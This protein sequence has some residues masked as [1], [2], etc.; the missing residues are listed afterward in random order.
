MS[1]Y[2]NLPA[3]AT[4]KYKGFA[5]IY[6]LAAEIV[7]YTDGRIDSENLKSFLKAYCLS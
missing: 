1:N 3:I 7:G 4:G 2:R 5:R 6:V